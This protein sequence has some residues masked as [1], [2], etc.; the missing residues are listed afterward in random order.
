MVFRQPPGCYFNRIGIVGTFFVF[1]LV[2]SRVSFICITRQ[3]DFFFAQLTGG[4]TYRNNLRLIV[5]STLGHAPLRLT[6]S[7]PKRGSIKIPELS[8]NLFSRTFEVIY[9]N[10][11]PKPPLFNYKTA[12]FLS[13]IFIKSLGNGLITE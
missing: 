6:I 11:C 10:Y 5:Y 4:K 12:I 9:F 3:S 7:P 13:E 2:F 8:F 1:L